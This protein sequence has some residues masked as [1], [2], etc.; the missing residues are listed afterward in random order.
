MTSSNGS[1]SK[2]E[3]A[4]GGRGADIEGKTLISQELSVQ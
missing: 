3:Q 2:L 1:F 4:E